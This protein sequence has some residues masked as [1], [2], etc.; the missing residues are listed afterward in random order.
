ME[1][2]EANWLCARFPVHKA[3]IRG[4]VADEAPQASDP[5]IV[6]RAFKGDGYWA[7]V[8]VR[9]ACQEP[10]GW[11]ASTAGLSAQRKEYTV[12]LHDLPGFPLKA[13]L[14]DVET[15][16]WKPLEVER[17]GD[18]VRM[19]LNSNW[20]LIT[21]SPAD[22]PA[23]IDVATLPTAAPGDRVTLKLLTVAGD[24]RQ[25]GPLS[26]SISAP[27]LTIEPAIA[28]VPGEAV[29]KVPPDALPGFYSVTVS[30]RQV[31][32]AKRFLRVK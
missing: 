22:G 6:T 14:C 12:S 24:P 21:L 1:Y 10:F 17:C 18:S 16:A 23:V 27:G 25:G 7:V 3:L 15:L 29:V 32:G 31:L 19:Q 8:A 30:G 26:V 20:A 11:P 5:E 28:T 13:S 2:L 4:D 9:P